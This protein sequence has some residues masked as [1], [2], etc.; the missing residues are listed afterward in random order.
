M[1]RPSSVEHCY[2]LSWKGSSDEI[3]HQLIHELLPGFSLDARAAPEKRFWSL[4]ELIDA[5]EFLTHPFLLDDNC[6]Y[7]S[8]NQPSD[9]SSIA[10]VIGRLV[11]AL[12][13]N[14]A[15]VSEVMWTL[16]WLSNDPQGN[17]E[18][19]EQRTHVIFANERRFAPFFSPLQSDALRLICSAL[20]TNT[21]CK[22]LSIQGAYVNGFFRA[23]HVHNIADSEIRSIADALRHNTAL[24][25]LNLVRAVHSLIL[26]SLSLQIESPM[27]AQKRLPNCFCAIERCAQ[28]TSR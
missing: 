23:A 8:G 3:S 27:L 18:N 17:I 4:Q 22:S 12:R 7:S 24:T 1:V 25:H 9:Q 13:D 2:A 6:A 14:D 10:Q 5:C 21:T 19:L 26:L 11:N 15:Q 28:S 20:T 16:N